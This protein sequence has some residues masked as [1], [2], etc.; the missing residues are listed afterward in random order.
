LDVAFSLIGV[1]M[2][3]VKNVLRCQEIIPSQNTF[4]C[5]VQQVKAKERKCII[6]STLKKTKTNKK[7]PWEKHG[8]Q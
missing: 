8:V 3:I 6:F 2:L 5:L 7:L 4:L 1:D